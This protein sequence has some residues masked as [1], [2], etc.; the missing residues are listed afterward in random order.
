MAV[1]LIQYAVALFEF[2][3]R[4]AWARVITAYFNAC[5]HLRLL[6]YGRVIRWVR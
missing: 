4:A 1:N 3:A 5:A 6:T 2:F